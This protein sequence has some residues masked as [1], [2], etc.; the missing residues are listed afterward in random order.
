MVAGI[1]F[2]DLEPTIIN[3][4]PAKV[5]SADLNQ[6]G[7]NFKLLMFIADGGDNDVWLISFNTLA[8]DLSGYNDL[9]YKI[10]TSFRVK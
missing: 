5:F 3:G 4:R 9:F 10:A 1:A 2:Q 6:Q 7:V 8:E